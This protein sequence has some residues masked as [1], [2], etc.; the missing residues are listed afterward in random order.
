MSRVS[1]WW[2]SYNRA[3]E[4]FIDRGEALLA[5]HGVLLFWVGMPL[6]LAVLTVVTVQLYIDWYHGVPLLG[7]YPMRRTNGRYSY[8]PFWVQL[9]SMTV[10][11][12]M[13]YVSAAVL[14]PEKPK[15][16]VWTE[17]KWRRFWITKWDFRKR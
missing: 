13:A 1:Q 17:R 12:L 7:H 9:L 11:T 2:R 3:L 8:V 6:V 5:P 16:Y 10:I 15:W 4:R 14:L